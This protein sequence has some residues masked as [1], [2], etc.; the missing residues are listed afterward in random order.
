MRSDFEQN[1][2]RAPVRRREFLWM[3][4]GA[5]LS[6]VLPAALLADD[7]PKT[8]GGTNSKP[9]PKPEP[10][11]VSIGKLDVFKANEPRQI[12]LPSDA[13]TV[14][15]TRTDKNTWESV[16]AKCTHRGCT[17]GWDAPN[18]EF[19]C[20]CHGAVFQRDGTNVHGPRRRPE[21]KLASLAPIPVQEKDSQLWVDLTAAAAAIKPRPPAPPV[22]PPAPTTPEQAP[23]PPP[24]PAAPAAG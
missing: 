24:A 2:E 17:V 5:G 8:D 21:P 16:S 11:W 12:V 13:G 10:K 19:L 3:A 15:I 22:P 7:T 23:A 6:L 20:P 9:D 14:W 4:A 18:K 1:G